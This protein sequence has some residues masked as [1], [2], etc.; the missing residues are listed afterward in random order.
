[1]TFRRWNA[2]TLS[3]EKLN[4]LCKELNIGRLTARVL[5][6]RGYDTPEKALSFLNEE[7]SFSSPFDLKDMDKAAARINEAIENDEVIAVFGDYDVDG[8]TSTALMYFYLQGCGARVVCSLPTRESTG[9]GLSSAAIDKMKQYDVSLIITVDNG[10]SAKDEVA[11]AKSLGIDTVVCDHHHA[12]LELPDAAAVVDPLRADDESEFKQ[13]AGVGVALKLAA[14]CEGCGVDEMLELYS[15]YAAI[16]TVS[17]IMPLTGENRRI[18]KAGLEALPYFENEG[19]AALCELSGIDPSTLSATD[20]A[21]TLAPRINAAGRMGNAALAL[22]LLI[23]EDP[24]EAREAA[25]QLC[26]LNKSRQSTEQEI[27]RLIE[28][29]ID[30]EPSLLREPVIIV[31]GENLHSGVIGIVCSRLVERYAKPAIVISVE[32]GEAKGS[33]RSIKGFSLYE[34]ICSCGDLLKKFGGHDMAAGFMMDEERLPEFKARIFEYCEQNSDKIKL[35]ELRVDSY[36]SLKEISQ[37]SVA[38]LSVLSPFGCAN[39]EPVF[40]VKGAEVVAVTG[41]GE[42][43]SRV[44]FREGG[45]SVSGALFSTLPASLGLSA[46]DRVDV[47]FNLSIYSSA[48]QKEVVSVKIKEIRKSGLTDEDFRSVDTYRS[49]CCQKKNADADRGLIALTRQDIAYVYKRLKAREIDR[50]DYRAVNSEF[51]ELRPG[52]ALA[53]CDVLEELGLAKQSR[54]G[55]VRVF[56]VC[57]TVEK[58]DL[59]ESVT[60]RILNGEIK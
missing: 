18:V 41:L 2:P 36:I 5:A 31:S 15:V 50:Y 45:E 3:D 49:F 47:A 22:K 52:K 6:A 35:P 32:G 39:E 21:F 38:E 24:E 59:N 56:A 25:K 12:P 46:G 27:T 43:H 9:Y 13:L 16:G 23:T 55:A 7:K 33:G 44:T 19:L 14:A 53:A 17:D 48:S 30:D 40:A 29:A 20:I 10:V 58:R 8:V 42:R 26:E 1:M 57:E 11:Y 4:S 60:F 37:G 34:A 54:R 28:E 51:Y